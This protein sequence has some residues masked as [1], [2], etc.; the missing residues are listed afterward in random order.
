MDTGR[1][2][3][4]GWRGGVD[5]RLVEV[6]SRSRGQRHR[7]SSRWASLTATK[8]RVAGLVAKGLTNPQI[9]ERMFIARGTVKADIAHIFTKLSV[10]SRAQLAAMAVTNLN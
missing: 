5:A 3:F 2:R 6:V 4:S 10:T 7:P 8:L 1:N 9:G